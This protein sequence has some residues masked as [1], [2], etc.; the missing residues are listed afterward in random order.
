MKTKSISHTTP[1]APAL[2]VQEIA[3]TKAKAPAS[4]APIAADPGQTR[5]TLGPQGKVTTTQAKNVLASRLTLENEPPPTPVQK[6]AE[7]LRRLTGAFEELGPTHAQLARELGT[8]ARLL[9]GERSGHVYGRLADALDRLGDA[10]WRMGEGDPATP[11]ALQARVETVFLGVFGDYLA[12]TG[13]AVRGYIDAAEKAPSLTTVATLEERGRYARSAARGSGKS[14]NEQFARTAERIAGRHPGAYAP[15]AAARV[16]LAKLAVRAHEVRMDLV[17][18]DSGKLSLDG[19]VTLLSID[20]RQASKALLDKRLDAVESALAQ[21][22]GRFATALFGAVADVVPN[23]SMA[24]LGAQIRKETL[25]EA[26]FAAR[27]GADE[28]PLSLAETDAI[29]QRLDALRP[30]IQAGAVGQRLDLL[31]RLLATGFD[32]PRQLEYEANGILA[33]AK[34]TPLGPEHLAVAQDLLHG[35]FR[36]RVNGEQ[37]KID[38]ALPQLTTA[39]AL[40]A[41]NLDAARNVV[42]RPRTFERPSELTFLD[43]AAQAALD[44]ALQRYD[45]TGAKAQA[46]VEALFDATHA[47]V[48]QAYAAIGKRPEAEQK[49]ALIELSRRAGPID[50]LSMWMPEGLSGPA[51]ALSDKIYKTAYPEG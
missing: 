44:A 21:G 14:E 49:A 1:P 6:A 29:S 38:A 36:A 45:D 8:G 5:A 46:Q 47:S 48:A 23:L 18:V 51:Q 13:E 26:T 31:Q 2:G 12:S 10:I 4:P 42:Q 20:P 35:V 39:T 32:T 37:Q 11:P 16:D 34:T 22:G 25:T 27:R 41:D 15:I 9:S 24:R 40:T 33:H 17:G 43:A 3:K 50:S 7:E 19:R 30:A 28:A